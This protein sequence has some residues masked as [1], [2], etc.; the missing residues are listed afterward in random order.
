MQIIAAVLL[1]SLMGCKEVDIDQINSAEKLSIVTTIE[2]YSDFVNNIGGSFVNVKTI[3]PS[4]ANAHNYE[5]SPKELL[6]ISK[7][8]VFFQVGAGFHLEQEFSF[9]DLLIVDCSE[10]I[11]LID[12]DPHVWLSPQNVKLIVKHI[13]KTLTRL[14]PQKTKYFEM[15]AESYSKQVDSAYNKIKSDFSSAK[16][17]Q[18][19]VYHNAWNYLA[20]DLDLIVHDIEHGG[21]KPNLGD[22]DEHI[23]K[24]KNQS[25]KIIYAD[26][27]L[28][29]KSAEMIANELNAKIEFINPLPSNYLENLKD[30]AK[31][32]GMV[33]N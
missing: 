15:N 24:G 13:T 11:E 12:K 21:K 17:R 1:L 19:F 20:R 2:P 3:I 25:V 29:S 28:S 14:L 9:H 4:G 30:V 16:N 33:L 18:V 22:I 32:F 27:N 10:G 23:K 31:K 8:D 26:S 7:A 5:P 6:I